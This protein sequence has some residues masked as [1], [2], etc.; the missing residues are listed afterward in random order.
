MSK[1]LKPCPFCGSYDDRPW[2]HEGYC[3]LRLWSDYQKAYY[4]S[5]KSAAQG[6]HS[7]EELKKAWNTRYERTAKVRLVDGTW[8]TCS[9]CGGFVR[10]YDIYCSQC[11]AKID[12]NA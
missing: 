8:D 6:L 10:E 12:R 9:L 4:L 5:G 7:A 3:Y 11:S 2:K 1:E